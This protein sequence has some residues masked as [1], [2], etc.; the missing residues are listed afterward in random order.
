[1]F[2]PLIPG[3]SVCWNNCLVL[4]WFR[5]FILKKGKLSVKFRFNQSRLLIR[6][7]YGHSINNGS[8]VS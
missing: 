2:I 3:L 1:M 4:L 8:I 5:E 6:V 7:R